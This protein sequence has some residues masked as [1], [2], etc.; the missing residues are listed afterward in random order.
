MDFKSFNITFAD[1]TSISAILN[2]NT[3]FTTE[4]KPED[5]TAD[6]LSEVNIDGFVRTNLVCRNAWEDDGFTKFIL[7]EKTNEEILREEADEKQID[8]ENAIAELTSL[9]MASKEENREMRN[10]LAENDD[11]LAELSEIMATL[12]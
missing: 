10:K 5:I 9:L 7:S 1:G 12:V 2:G 8:S 3:Y 6:K 4:I 11:A